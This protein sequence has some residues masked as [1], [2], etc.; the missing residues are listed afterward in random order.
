MS[1]WPVKKPVS[2]N[3]T[4]GIDQKWPRHYAD[5]IEPLK[6]RAKRQAALLKVP[7]HW[8]KMIE[9]HLMDRYERRK[10]KERQK[11]DAKEKP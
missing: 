2:K 11:N 3:L 4:S 1:G 5:E 8:R 9:D 10:L 7:Q 6:P